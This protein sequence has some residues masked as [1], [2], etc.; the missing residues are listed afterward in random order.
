[1]TVLV[2][3]DDFV[4]RFVINRMCEQLGYACVSVDDGQ[5]CLDKVTEAHSEIDVVL[6]DIHMPR[7][8]GTEVVATMRASEVEPLKTLPVIAVTADDNWK[9]VRRCIENGFTGVIAKPVTL[10]QLSTV[11]SKYSK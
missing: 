2:V 6:L 1:M 7:L 10:P 3:E 9:D 5:G 4:T 8:S 11:L